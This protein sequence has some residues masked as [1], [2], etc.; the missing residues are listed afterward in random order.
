MPKYD[1]TYIV[2]RILQRCE[3]V[4]TEHAYRDDDNEDFGWSSGLDIQQAY[5][6]ARKLHDWIHELRDKRKE[7]SNG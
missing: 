6:V 1:D 7:K 3:E 4:M 5:W 2:N